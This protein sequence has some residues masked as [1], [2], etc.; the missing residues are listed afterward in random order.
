MIDPFLT[1]GPTIIG[2]SGGRTSAMM[3]RR[4]L[5]AHGGRLP[6]H[7]YPVFANTGKERPET[8][9]FLARCAE[10]WG[11]ELRWIERDRDEGFVEVTYETASRNGEPFADLIRQRRYLPNATERICTIELK[12]KASAA[13]MRAQGYESWTN[14]VGFR[15]DEPHRVAKVR[16]RETM[17]EPEEPVQ[18]ALGINAGPKRRRRK[19][20]AQEWTSVFPLHAAR[21]TKADVMAFWAAQPFDL[22][23]RPW[24]SNCDGCPLKSSAI[25][26]RTERERPGTM[27][28]WAEQEYRVGATFTKG[29]TY[30]R[31]IE[32]AQRPP[33]PGMLADPTDEDD[34]PLPCSCTDRRGDRWRCICGKHRNGTRGHTLLCL[35]AREDARRAA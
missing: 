22:A 7:V 12:I 27:A 5:D 2:V 20:P 31:V 8:L 11:S 18:L 16:A 10:S 3:W 9:D 1:D 34:A 6:P 4:I 29:R 26:E 24:E 32:H 13:F 19:R 25:L 17:E 14:V 30:L 23:L 15:R 21:V 33:F 28:W 35:V